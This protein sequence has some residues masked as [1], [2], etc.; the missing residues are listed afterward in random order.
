MSWCSSEQDLGRE[1]CNLACWTK[2]PGAFHPPWRPD[3]RTQPCLES[4]VKKGSSVHHPNGLP[5]MSNFLLGCSTFSVS[6]LMSW[7]ACVAHFVLLVLPKQSR[8]ESP[9]SPLNS[10]KLTIINGLVHQ[11]K[12]PYL[13]GKS[14]VSCKISYQLQSTSINF[15]QLQ[16][17]SV[18]HHPL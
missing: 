2:R 3:L 12:A 4:W 14:M 13:M 17:T 7:P 1:L 5:M 6:S 16:S 18:F 15:N 9:E 11:W 10:H 8:F